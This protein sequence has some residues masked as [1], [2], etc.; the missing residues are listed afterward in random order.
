MKVLFVYR[1]LTLGGVETVL[2]ARLDGLARRGIEAHA[3]FFHDLGGRSVFAGREGLVHLGNPTACSA[4]LARGRFDAVGSID[5]EE[6][7]PLF[8][9]RGARPRLLVECHSPYLANIE[10]L[11]GLAPLRPAAVFVPSEYQRRIVLERVGE[12]IEVVVIPNPL[13]EDFVDEPRP[14]GAPVP[15][16]VVAWVGR[17]DEL[18]NWKGFLEL[19][20]LLDRR[21]V[22]FEAWMAGR[23]TEAG[24]T[25]E[26]L[27]H[28]RQ[29][30]VLPRL[31]WFRAL[32]HER[33]PAFFDAVRDSGGVV[34][35]TSKGESFGMT[36]AEAMARGCAVAVP[37][38]PPFTEFVE[39]GRT[40]C[41][42][43]PGPEGAA[44]Q[45]AS[46]LADP[47]RRA[48]SGR[49]ARESILARFAPEV[50]LEALAR[51]LR[52]ICGP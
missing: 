32:P 23:S 4:F 35:S 17:L 29:L 1:Y 41:F 51:E 20:R 31:R 43:P 18:K 36:V 49:N 47:A 39:E 27:R 10:Y 42:F 22:A 11:R 8:A 15:R 52:R 3:W 46:L 13:R 9:G 21:G 19:A 24:S 40:G 5:T 30:G 50:A 45:V 33:V 28:A 16:P 34:V 44:E 38:Q 37:N 12:G 25:A 2:R 26:L 7:F 48:E 6:V 14:F